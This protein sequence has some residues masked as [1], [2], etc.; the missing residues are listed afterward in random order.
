MK[1]IDHWMLALLGFSLAYFM[2]GDTVTS[3]VFIIAWSVA[4]TIKWFK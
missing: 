1:L 2:K 4:Y 3:S